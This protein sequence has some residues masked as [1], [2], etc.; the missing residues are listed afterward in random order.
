M[1]N[2]EKLSRR[3][4]INLVGTGGAA[5]LL[6]ACLPKGE[7]I[8]SN[9]VTATPFTDKGGE[10]DI[11][12][13]LRAV[14]DNVQI[15]TG[16]K[17]QVWRYQGEVTRGPDNALI[18]IQD[19]Y[20]GPIFNVQTG[21]TIRVHFSNELPESSIVHWHGLHVPVSADGHPRLAID[22]GES[23]IYDFTVAD[24]AGMYWYH[25]HPHGRTGTQV[26]AG[27]A[28][29]FII[30]D[31]NEFALELP[32]GD[33][34]LPIV[35]QDRI[36]DENNQLV[37]G[38]NG[39]MDQMMG[40]LGDQLLIN[41]QAD[42]SLTVETRPYRLRLLNGSNS[43]I[44]KLAWDDGTPLT[45]IGTDGGLLEKPVMREYI[46]LAPAQRIELWVDFSSD[47]IGAER[48]LVNLPFSAY[49]G[50]SDYQVLPVKIE[51][52][53]Q[54][55]AS[56]PEKLSSIA[57]H[58]INQAVN[59]RSPR[60]IEMAMGMGM[61][62][63]LNGRTFEMETVADDEI[64]KLGNLEVWEFINRTGSGMGMMNETLPH[65][66]HV[67]GLQYQI[68]EREVGASG[69]DVWESLKDGFVDEGWHDTVLVLPGERVKIALKFEDFTGLYLYHCH[70]LEHEDMGMMRNYRVDV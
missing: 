8:T 51:K 7:V 34:D 58:D 65:P 59:R 19:S 62:W 42:F 3:D 69:R 68:V 17:T 52:A 53:V 24:R 41:G 49:G 35:L 28:G 5:L 1:T 36:F 27:M 56:L 23:Y 12:I 11:E 32:S 54:V 64:V 21:Q 43:R 63:S 38:G 48:N 46:T 4:F 33:Y 29:L 55:A 13:S 47:E 44:Y 26:Y 39:M 22:P 9:A 30:H 61:R 37:Y 6:S 20:L 67:H 15:L 66:M 10:P 25:P 57:A 31:E 50:T 18:V 16:E 70:N 14:A 40:F 2:S 60:A 45:V